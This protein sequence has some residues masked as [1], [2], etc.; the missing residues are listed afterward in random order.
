MKTRV[1]QVTFGKEGRQQ[2][3]AGIK[4]MANLV[5]ITLGP[6]G[7][8]VLLDRPFIA[9]RPTKDGVT[10]AQEVF[11]EDPIENLGAQLVKEAALGAAKVAGDGTT[12]ATVLAHAL[13]EE[14]VDIKEDVSLREIQSF[15]DV[16]E[17]NILEFLNEHMLPLDS[18]DQA[19]QIATIAANGDEELGRLIGGTH[20]DLGKD[21]LLTV[22]NSFTRKT[23]VE[24][25]NGWE[26]EAGM[27]QPIF[28]NNPVTSSCDL[29]NCKILLCKGSVTLKSSK[30]FQT[31]LGALFDGKT[32]GVGES[33]IVVAD[34][35]A[36]QVVDM[37]AE[38]V[39]RHKVPI[40]LVKSPA[41]GETRVS[42]LEDLACLTGAELLNL[43][44]MSRWDGK[45]LGTL[46]SC[47]SNQ[48]RTI[49]MGGQG[50]PRIIEEREQEIA[51]EL[52][53][54][55]NKEGESDPKLIDLLERRLANFCGGIA[56]VKVG[57]ET[58]QEVQERADRIDDAI[59][60]VKAG[61]KS[62][63]LQGGGMALLRYSG[64]LSSEDV[65][66]V[67][68]RRV[69]CRPFEIICR[70]AGH[71]PE[72]LLQ[73]LVDTNLPADKAGV[74]AR[75]GHVVDMYERGIIDPLLVVQTTVQK[76]FSVAKSVLSAEGILLD[77]TDYEAV[78]KCVTHYVSSRV[79]GA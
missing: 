16:E 71:D 26:L 40:C 56:V 76:A 9:P 70:N 42:L 44:H 58:E 12:T 49:F 31:I 4:K 59:R 25:T 61:L 37:V 73:S 14:L 74:D 57:G 6:S 67:A 52:A 20:F 1:K 68:L 53:L 54:E 19:I 28:I 43:D 50:N 7:E 11:L 21:G 38:V 32:L 46:E 47:T 22:K 79:K 33:L 30:I 10:I 77:Q 62:G 35:Y 72:V 45:G 63:F 65:L 18:R 75:T 36:Y 69:L 78:H 41:Y 8:C 23:F 60:A 48:T 13:I 29:G 5:K 55:R 39:K 3:V 24:H 27:I 17:H 64:T 2:L 66:S 15:L 51:Q 34:E